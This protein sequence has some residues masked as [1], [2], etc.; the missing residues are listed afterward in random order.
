[1]FGWDGMGWDGTGW[2]GM[3]IIECRSFKSTFG[4]KGRVALPNRFNFRKS[5]KGGVGV[6]FNPK[7][8]VV[9]FG[10]QTGPL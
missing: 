9:D 2:D 8:Y 4:A 1:M 6:I 5:S 3:V 10:L 7:I